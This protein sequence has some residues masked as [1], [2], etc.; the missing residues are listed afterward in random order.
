MNTKKRPQGVD[1]GF[2]LFLLLVFVVIFLCWFLCS[3]SEQKKNFY[4]ILIQIYLDLSGSILIYLSTNRVNLLPPAPLPQ[5]LHQCGTRR[6][7]AL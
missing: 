6:P 1:V 4:Y 3:V 7:L 5:R 2:V